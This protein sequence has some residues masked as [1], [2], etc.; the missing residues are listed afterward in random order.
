[1]SQKITLYHYT[2]EESADSINDSKIMY[3]STD[4]IADARWGI[5]VYFT[6]M[7]PDDFTPDKIAYNNWRQTLS[8][9][10]GRKLKY[11]I[12][13]KFP[14]EVIQDCCED[15]RRIFLYP[16]GNVDLDLYEHNVFPTDF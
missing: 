2:D 16:G 11:C 14:K 13:V 8:S 9:E 3:Q 4:T 7:K 15:D 5:G 12:E 10:I 6:D 1:M